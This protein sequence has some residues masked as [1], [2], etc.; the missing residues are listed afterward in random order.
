M[1]PESSLDSQNRQSACPFLGRLDDPGTLMS[2]PSGEN[3]CHHA[4]PV[5]P[6][7]S[8]YQRKFC[9]T[10]KHTR[11]AVFD[12][13]K[14][15]R[16]PPDLRLPAPERSPLRT[17][18]WIWLSLML[19]LL[20]IGVVL[21]KI[22][23]LPMLSAG[24]SSLFKAGL[25]AP[26]LTD[27]PSLLSSMQLP[28]STQAPLSRS[29]QPQPGLAAQAALAPTPTAAAPL[30]TPSLVRPTPDPAL[31]WLLQPEKDIH[32]RSNPPLIIHQVHSGENVNLYADFYG[33]TVAAIA[34]VNVNI[35][36]PLWVGDLL[37]IPLGS[38]DVSGLPAFEPYRVA[39]GPQPLPVLASR[40]GVDL[41][42]LCLHNGLPQDAL[43]AAGDWLILPR[44]VQE[45]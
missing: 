39:E 44:P 20:I 32:I 26:V 28:A 17:T 4:R 11:C 19:L 27:E 8:D 38:V 18:R 7:N 13:A 1:N 35:R 10:P 24:F 30:P 16:L 40:L 22:N 14:L 41:A 42:S 43:M 23:R 34:H 45:D 3:C 33:T 15:R 29:G 37:V 25:S 2:F 12:L 5:E 6:V 31:A 9:L 21:V 36:V